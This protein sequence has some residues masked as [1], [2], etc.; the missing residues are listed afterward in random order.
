VD[1]AM[2]VIKTKIG[3]N[4]RNLTERAALWHFIWPNAS[5]VIERETAWRI[6]EELGR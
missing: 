2:K 3:S 4:M 5:H 1:K 6:L